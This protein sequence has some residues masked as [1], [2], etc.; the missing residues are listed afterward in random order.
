MGWGATKLDINMTTPWLDG[1]VMAA[2]S[3]Y[4]YGY[5]STTM[6]KWDTSFAVTNGADITGYTVKGIYS[7]STIGKIFAVLCST[8][9]DK[10]GVYLSND[11]GATFTTALGTPVL[12]LGDDDTQGG[13]QKHGSSGGLSRERYQAPAITCVQSTTSTGRRP[14]VRQQTALPR[15]RVSRKQPICWWGLR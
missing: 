1:Q 2:D 12:Q 10:C 5:K 3:S 13:Y 11:G 9:S 7:T 6:K 4:A 8:L 15:S 14:T